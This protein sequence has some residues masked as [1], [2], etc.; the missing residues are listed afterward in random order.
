METKRLTLR[1]FI[2]S[3]SASC[4]E[5]WG[6]DKELGK[7]IISYPM[8]NVQQMDH[9]IEGLLSNEHAWLITHKTTTEAIGYVTLDIP[10]EQL[11]I[12]EIAYVIGAKYQHQGYAS[13]AL[14]CVLEEY[15]INRRLY[16][17]EAKYNE[18]NIAS[19]NLLQKLGFHIDGI[20]RE[21]RIDFASGK[22]TNLVICSLTSEELYK[23]S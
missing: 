12:G 20:L 2:K 5:G 17:I 4:F 18:T 1:H 16:M 9:Y 15:L 22:R 8:K 14:N 11:G 23:N 10:Y 21:R 13:E 7:Y 6:Q 19:K 3:D